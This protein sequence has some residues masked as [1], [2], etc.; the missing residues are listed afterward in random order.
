MI[1]TE[2]ESDETPVDA[3]LE[4]TRALAD[5]QE[6]FHRATEACKTALNPEQLCEYFS[7]VG[8]DLGPPFQRLSD[9]RSSNDEAVCLMNTPNM[10]PEMPKGYIHHHII[11]PT[12]LDAVLQVMIPA[13]TR[14]GR[15]LMPVMIPTSFR[16][17]W[18]SNKFEAHPKVKHMYTK[19]RYIGF[20][21][22]A[23]RLVALKENSKEPRAVVKSFHATAVSGRNSTGDTRTARRLCFNVDR[24]PDPSL[25]NQVRADKVIKAPL[26]NPAELPSGIIAELES[27]CYMYISKFIAGCT[28]EQVT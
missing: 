14:G 19:S 8:L 25:L 10:A 24:K 16:E 4:A 5:E 28:T 13:L 15:E 12:T 21:Q 23:A 9:V 1:L 17:L 6:D 22:S 11:H 26:H 27:V 20:R 2:Y 3:G 7:T 18:S